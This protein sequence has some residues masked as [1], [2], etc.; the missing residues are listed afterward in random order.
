[1]K[2]YKYITILLC[3]LSTFYVNAEI[4]ALSQRTISE[5]N[6]PGFELD[7]IKNFKKNLSQ[8]ELAWL[9]QRESIVVGVVKPFTPPFEVITSDKKLEGISADILSVLAKLTGKNVTI[10]IF[11]SQQQALSAIKNRSVDILNIS[12]LLPD[13]STKTVG[14]FSSN[15]MLDNCAYLASIKSINANV[16]EPKIAYESGGMDVDSLASAYPKAVLIPF[17]NI[18]DAY[19]AVVF[20]KADAVV[21]SISSLTYLN[22]SRLNGLPVKERTKISCAPLQFFIAGHNPPLKKIIDRLISEMQK[23]SLMGLTALR[24]RGGSYKV[25]DKLLKRLSPV[26][27]A[28][29]TSEPVVRV[30]LIPNDFP[31]SFID[32]TRQWQG[33]IIDVLNNVRYA[34]GLS[35]D[36]ISYDSSEALD[37]AMSSSHIDMIGNTL[38]DIHSAETLH[39]IYY[40]KDDFLVLLSTVG[41]IKKTS[42]VVIS[43]KYL[44][45]LSSWSGIQYE[46]I[47]A[48]ND[49]REV[50]QYFEDGNS[51]FAIV[52]QYLA[53]Y[54][55][56]LSQRP[57]KVIERVGP[58]TLQRTFS[59]KENDK[60]L[61]EVMNSAIASI[62]PSA[63]SDIAYF[64]RVT[65]L[66][67]I[68][69]YAQYADKIKMLA[70]ILLPLLL[71]YILYSYRIHHELSTRKKLEKVLLGQLDLMQSLLDG[72]PHPVT[73]INADGTVIYS[74]KAFLTAVG[75]AK[76]CTK[77]ANLFSFFSDD[78][79]F[80]NVVGKVVRDMEIVVRDNKVN[81]T[82]SLIDIQEWFIPYHNIYDDSTGVLW[83]WFDVTWRNE[84]CRQ[85]ELSKHEADLAN[86]AKSEF[87]ATISHE[88]RTPINIINGFLTLVLE[89]T[90][91]C[92][93]DREELEYTKSAADGL[94]CLVGDVLDVTKIE[95]G[96]LSLEL[97]PI[98]IGDLVRDVVSM[99]STMT[100]EKSLTLVLKSELDNCLIQLDPLRTKQILFNLIGNA[101]KFTHEGTIMVSAWKSD[102]RINISVQDSGIGIDSDKLADLFKPFVQVHGKSS[103][104]GTGLGLNITKRLC[105]LM[106][107]DVAISSEIGKGTEVNIVLPYQPVNM[108]AL[109]VKHKAPEKSGS[110]ILPASVHL[111]II[112]D[113]PVNLILL[114][115]RLT[116]LGFENIHEADN[117]W[118]ALEIVKSEEIH[119]IITDCQMLGMDGFTLVKALRQY[120]VDSGCTR[121]VILG[122]T[123]SG[124]IQDREKGMAAGMDAC[125]FKPID[126]NALYGELMAH[127]DHLELAELKNTSADNNHLLKSASFVEMLQ[128]LTTADLVL[129]RNAYV[130]NDIDMFSM[131]IHRI[132]GV[133][134]MVRHDEIV[135]CCKEIEAHLM[136]G[137]HK[138]QIIDGLDHIK[139]LMKHIENES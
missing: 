54:Y 31:Y 90:S 15:V 138:Q 76:E 24:W 129:A 13:A 92:D 94:L 139:A 71:A 115:R 132:K 72:L 61:L 102:N 112:D 83:G 130:D 119:I 53:D 133:F 127:L 29:L 91:L 101:V 38:S 96:L 106:G 58:P 19:D 43:E 32:P 22:K 118:Q 84:I 114:R 65:P 64:W 28:W 93:I 105:E 116:S 10:K 109:P 74:N 9:A 1:M 16:N 81:I 25:S 52:P 120:E 51:D 100:K 14:L 62:S 88:I 56:S 89:R 17:E 124:I 34:S 86:Q 41:E 5:T 55:I 73:L 37:K 46:N 134:L 87:I 20:G 60:P 99:F 11:E 95:A 111:L 136:D 108:A 85:L 33:I 113:H 48:L 78:D 128:E 6:E 117:G 57:Y 70:G 122:L 126:N 137:T 131:L 40:N 30:G 50:M 98:N 80:L 35:F 3:M 27:D 82:G 77:G 75:Y 23:S 103:Y 42:R 66:P 49:D 44:N 18:T 79:D 104:Q 12:S 107:G 63:L 135:N 21:G 4:L 7:Y 26:A 123:A 125:M 110:I 47:I 97:S 8:R 69:F 68:G 45:I 2:K 36:F 121:H 59:M 39:S 67:K